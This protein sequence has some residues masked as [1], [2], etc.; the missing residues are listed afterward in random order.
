MA[1]FPSDS[2]RTK[3]W[4]TEILTDSDLEGQFDVIHNYI[5]AALNSSTG[6]DHDGTSNQGPKIGITNMTVASQAAG[7]LIVASSSSAWKRLAKGTASQV[8]SM[9]SDASDVE[10]A[11][12]NVQPDGSV[13]QVVNTQTGATA[14]G[15]TT[16]PIDDTIPQSNEGVEF[17]TLAITPKSAT[18]KLRIDVVINV[19]ED[20]DVA[21]Y[22]GVALFQDSTANALAAVHRSVPTQQGSYPVCFTHYMTSGTTSATTFK[23]RAGLNAA[24]NIRINGWGGTRYFG[25]VMA[26]SITITEIKAS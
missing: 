23:V 10:W 24:G 11:T 19:T 21:D 15:S 4:G 17:M 3:N 16:M 18:N 20:T 13:V 26:S 9:K 2:I 5:Q 6:H 25:G 7:D 1:T 8:L 12:L 14:T 22:M